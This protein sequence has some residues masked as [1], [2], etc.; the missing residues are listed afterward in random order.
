MISI[1]SASLAHQS[2]GNSGNMDHERKFPR[3]TFVNIMQLIDVCLLDVESLRLVSLSKGLKTANPFQIP[4]RAVNCSCSI[5]FLLSKSGIDCFRIQVR[6]K[7]NFDYLCILR[8]NRLFSRDQ[9]NMCVRWMTR[10]AEALAQEGLKPMKRLSG[11]VSIFKKR[12]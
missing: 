6:I 7:F 10:F 3:E 12:I 4:N 9:L 11:K 5:S 1:P 8:K 2:P